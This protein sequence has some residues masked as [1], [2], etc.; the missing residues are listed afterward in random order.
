MTEIYQPNPYHVERDFYAVDATGRVP[1]N[2]KGEILL[3]DGTVTLGYPPTNHWPYFSFKRQSV[4]RIVAL[5]FLECP[6]NPKNYHVNHIDGDKG[7]NEVANLEW[8]T[9]STNATHAYASGLRKDNRPVLA[10]NLKTGEITSFYS[11]QACARHF[12]VSGALI[13]SYLKGD[14]SIPWRKKWT[15]TYDGE[16]WSDL[17]KDDIGKSKG[18]P[19]EIISVNEET[20]SA[21]IYPS[22]KV[23]SDWTGIKSV[24]LSWYLNKRG[25]D[26]TNLYKGLRWYFLDEY[27][28][29]V[30]GAR[31]L[32]TAKK[33]KHRPPRRLP[34]KVKVTDLTT[35]QQTLWESLRAKADSD[36]WKKNSLEKAIWRN[37]GVVKNEFYEYV[38]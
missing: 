7:N 19:K 9:A 14:R 4:H 36:G 8:V 32:G 31:R 12:K 21:V 24:T 34:K 13:H 27:V 10:K 35:G 33:Y 17:S 18:V 1:V 23:A 38:T 29:N 11:L 25:A 6:G 15:F 26:Q 3:D 37:K 2:R 20:D 22:I 16:S 28:G 5:T 30:Q